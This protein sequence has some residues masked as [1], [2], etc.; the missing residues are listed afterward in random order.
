MECRCR[1]SP[2]QG[3]AA[4][5]I[6]LAMM[7]VQKELERRKLQTIMTMQVHD[8]LVFETPEREKEEA[9]EMIREQMQNVCKLIVPLTV[10]LSI[11]RNWREA[12]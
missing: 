5:I 12:K 4:D 9:A 3:S 10:D 11:G 1:C 8:E 6:K 2:L 7:A